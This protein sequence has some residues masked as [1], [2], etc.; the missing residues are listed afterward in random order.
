MSSAF[1][2]SS[3]SLALSL[4]LICQVF[5]QTQSSS[6]SSSAPLTVARS[7]AESDLRAVVEK[8][9]ALYAG[10]DLEGLMSLWSEKSPDHASFRQSLRGQFAAENYSF[11]LPA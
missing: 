11:S 6:S 2:V 10:K 8:Y 5:S 1:R 9:F 4:S 7:P 3:F